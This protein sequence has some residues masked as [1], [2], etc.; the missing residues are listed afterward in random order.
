[1]DTSHNKP[2][3]T[4]GPQLNERPSFLVKN[5]FT[6]ISPQIPDMRGVGLY[7]LPIFTLLTT[8]RPGTS[9]L[10]RYG[11]CNKTECFFYYCDDKTI[12]DLLHIHVQTAR[13]Q[14]PIFLIIEPRCKETCPQGF[15]NKGT[16][17]S[18]QSEQCLHF[19]FSGIYHLDLL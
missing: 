5:L 1:M 18:A 4:Q 3:R 7:W 2:C 8:C 12:L 10:C 16:D 6:S 9:D 19:L 15:A 11:E 17:H 13:Q 14:P